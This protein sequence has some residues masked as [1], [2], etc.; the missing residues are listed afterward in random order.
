VHQLQDANLQY[1]TSEGWIQ[2]LK[3]LIEKVDPAYI[4]LGAT[5]HG[6]DLAAMLSATLDAG[7]AID[8]TA[9][10]ILDDGTAEITRPIYA[11][12]ALAKLRFKSLPGIIAIRPNVFEPAESPT[13]GRIE[14]ETPSIGEIRPMVKEI[15][16]KATG[17]VELTEADIVVAGGRGLEEAGN[18]KLIEELADALGGAC[19]ASRVIVD[20]GWV[21][22]M[23]Q[24]GQTGKTV[25]PKLYFAI[26]IAGAIQHLAGM[27][28][29]K[30]VVAINSD[31]EAPIFKVADYGIVGDALKILPIMTEEF[32]KACKT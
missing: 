6:R 26:G 10:D 19:A 25:S 29:S 31:P 20:A 4:L 23:H 28:S 1:Y 32:K 13:E 30:I 16:G 7:A 2:A 12:K 3:P 8:V 17:R 5:Y 18:F 14:T 22:H 11:G 21:E 24:V 15:I 27:S 9:I